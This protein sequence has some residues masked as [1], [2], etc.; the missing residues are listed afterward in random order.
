MVDF[1][2]LLS[3][4][5]FLLSANDT[6]ALSGMGRGAWKSRGR[7]EYITYDHSSAFVYVVKID[8]LG[9]PRLVG[10]IVLI[11]AE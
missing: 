2:R 10:N 5:R 11:K 7:E 3:T 6:Y 4:C 9:N 1:R 8:Y